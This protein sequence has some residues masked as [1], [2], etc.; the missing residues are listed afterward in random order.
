MF[1][2]ASPSPERIAFRAALSGFGGQLLRNLFQPP[3]RGKPYPAPRLLRGV[4]FIRRSGDVG[5]RVIGQWQVGVPGPVRG[6]EWRTFPRGKRR[7]QSP[8]NT[9]YAA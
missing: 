6:T 5:N 7:P 8:V 4:S 3:K 1:M 2:L 9:G